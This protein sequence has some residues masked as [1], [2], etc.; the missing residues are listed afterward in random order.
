METTLILTIDK[1]SISDMLFVQRLG[2]YL[3]P[4]LQSGR[5]VILVH[6]GHD[7]A[8]DVL[9]M[10]GY[11]E[12]P[13]NDPSAASEVAQ[14]V[15]VAVR[16]ATRRVVAALT[17]EGVPAAGMQ[18]ADRGL[19][20]Q[21]EGGLQCAGINQLLAMTEIGT[22][23]VVGPV[24]ST[25][26]ES[27]ALASASSL[28]LAIA[29]RIARPETVG[30]AALVVFRPEILTDVEKSGLNTVKTDGSDAISTDFLAICIRPNELANPEFWERFT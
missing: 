9:D 8:E 11:D 7:A 1:E 17:E 28:S 15:F 6:D 30:G 25:G 21:T 5:R 29:Q 22:V 10:L 13:V 18:G 27:M 16:E 4:S 3:S 12:M 24:V 20:Q 26:R 2:R 19:V 23:P 14:R